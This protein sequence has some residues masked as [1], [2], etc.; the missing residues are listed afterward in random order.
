LRSGASVGGSR[1]VPAEPSDELPVLKPNLQIAFYY[2]LQELKS[3]YLHEALRETVEE[4]DIVSLDDELAQGVPGD[5]LKRVASFGLRG[6]VFFA[7]PYVLERNP[8][9]VGYYRLLLGFSKKEFYNKGPFGRFQA[10][11]E[12]GEIPDA[13]R[14]EIAAFCTSLV[15]SAEILV[16]NT[17][18]LSLSLVRDL[19]V[20]TLGPQ[21][22]GGHNTRIGQ[23][24]TR[25]VFTLMQDIVGHNAVD[26]SERMILLRND[27]RRMVTIEFFNDPDV[28]INEQLTTTTRPLVSIEIKGGRDRSNIH[29]RLGEAEKSHQKAKERGFFQFW[30]IIRCEVDPAIARQESPTT[31]HFF[32]LDRIK[33]PATPEHRAF[34]ELLGALV[35]IQV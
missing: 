26:V 25:E 1:T 2:R 19:Q 11:E 23:T 18:D 4:A 34:R 14:A 3:L 21:L 22:R 15:K 27:S 31:T 9:L 20:L 8:F 17:D 13:I 10:L 6:E 35:G 33:D 24:A 16:A 29:N 7:V 12:R 5:S 28:R 32:N 30:T